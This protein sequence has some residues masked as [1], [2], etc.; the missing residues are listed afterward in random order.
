MI[1][2]LFR[3]V[4]TLV[5][6][7]IILFI[8]VG[9]YLGNLA[10]EEFRAAPWDQV[11]GIEN[12]ARDVGPARRA[13]QRYG[14]EAVTVTAED[15]TKLRGTY[16]EDANR[17]HY[18]VI[19]L[20]GLYQNRSMCLPY[21]SMYRNMGYNVLLV[22]LRGHGESGGEHTDWGL[23]ERGDLDQWVQWLK[24][25]DSSVHI[26]MHGVSLGA[27]MAL[28][29]SGTDTGRTLQFYVADSAYGNLTQLGRDKVLAWAGDKRAVWGFNTLNP[30]FQAAMYYHN[31]QLLSD[32]E[33]MRSVEKMTSP[34]LF[35]HGSA[36]E[37]IPV[38]TVQELYDHSRS[39]RKVV[40]VFRGSG[41]AV[42]IG[43][44]T[45]EYERVL[46]NFLEG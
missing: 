3:A 22:D 29:Y 34:V 40:H 15:G 43:T 7:G 14:W 46:S 19:L 12:H 45:D 5:A 1:R 31:R 9:L 38:E 23:S 6:A 44:D 42:G 24:K 35:L 30:F 8:G 21:V 37:L 4:R 28:L 26:G 18:T 39:R 20:H 2:W 36:D 33:P 41:H 25:R 17:S 27:A 32:L 11:L 16:I 13:E 10:Y